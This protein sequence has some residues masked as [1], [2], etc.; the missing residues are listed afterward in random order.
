L[1][2][3]KRHLNHSRIDADRPHIKVN[4]AESSA[5]GCLAQQCVVCC[6][7]SC[8]GNGAKQV[9]LIT[10]GCV[11]CGTCRIVCGEFHNVD[12]NCP[13]GGFDIL[14]KFG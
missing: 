13:R 9:R 4:K 2:E 14:Y 5:T 10:E 7:A 11:E 1:T 8:W 12:W 6:P 3:K